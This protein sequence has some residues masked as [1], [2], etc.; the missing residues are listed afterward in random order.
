VDPLKVKEITR[1]ELLA[2]F[3]GLARYS[4]RNT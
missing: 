2:S 3:L 1:G 4:H